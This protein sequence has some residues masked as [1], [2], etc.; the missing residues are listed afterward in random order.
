[1]V[2]KLGGLWP[3]ATFIPA[4]FIPHASSPTPQTSLLRP[5]SRVLSP[6]RPDHQSRVATKEKH[7]RP[8]RRDAG[9][10]RPRARE[11]SQEPGSGRASQVTQPRAVTIIVSSHRPSHRYSLSITVCRKVVKPEL[12]NA[13]KFERS[14][15]S[16]SLRSCRIRACS[17]PGPSSALAGDR[18]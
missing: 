15:L 7:P 6:I 18:R 2:R 1:M 12:V 9:P 16:F 5:F 17:N 11:G 4:T 13:N 3:C 8:P 14:S 10:A